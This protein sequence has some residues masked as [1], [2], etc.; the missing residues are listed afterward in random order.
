M[1]DL[2]SLNGLFAVYVALVIAKTILCYSGV[3]FAMGVVVRRRPANS[4]VFWLV[5][6]TVGIPVYVFFALPVILWN[7]KSSFFVTYSKWSVMRQ[8]ARTI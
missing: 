5:C 6:L 2:F 8:V 4:C 3:H 7:E 1:F